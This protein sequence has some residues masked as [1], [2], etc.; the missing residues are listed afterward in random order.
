M[1]TLEIRRLSK[2]LGL[3][4][5]LERFSLEVADS[6]CVVVLGPSGSGKT[7]LLRL[8]AGLEMPDEGEI[9]LNGQPASRPGWVLPP[10][11]R[12]LG[13]VFQLPVLWPHMTA[14]ENIRFGLAHL[15]RDEARQRTTDL[16][17][18]LALDGL[19]K[20]YPHELSGGEARRVAL[21]RA[22]APRPKLLLM[23]EPLTNLNPELKQQVIAVIHAHLE[24]YRPTLVYVTHDSQEATAISSQ[25]IRLFKRSEA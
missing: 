19:A 4:Q 2:A 21:A 15:N 20:R 24:K 18:W 22:L 9:L 17:E 16:L 10:H 25:V 7:T 1:T 23:D 3:V 12:G 14:V 11:L 8:I 13:M 5:V 6:D